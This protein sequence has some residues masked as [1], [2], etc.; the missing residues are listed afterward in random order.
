MCQNPLN[1]FGS[2]TV[3]IQCGVSAGFGI[4]FVYF[5]KVKPRWT[6]TKRSGGSPLYSPL[7]PKVMQFSALLPA[8]KSLIKQNNEEEIHE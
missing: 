3:M 1:K 6:E 4:L 5:I 7:Y 8:C 2:I